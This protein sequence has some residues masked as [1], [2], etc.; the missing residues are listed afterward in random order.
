MPLISVL[1]PVRQFDE[2][3][4]PAIDSVL[5]QTHENLELLLITYP[6]DHDWVARLPH[7]HRLKILPRH[8]DGIVSALN[9][10]IDAATGH[11]IAR[12]DADDL[13]TPERLSRQLAHLCEHDRLSM[14]GAQVEIFSDDTTVQTGNRDY[15]NWLNAALTPEQIRDNIYV[16]SPLPHPTLFAATELFRQFRYR[17]SA[18]AEDYDLLLRLHLAGLLMGKPD[19]ILLRWREH[20]QRL[21]RQSSR[22]SIAQFLNAKAWALSQQYPNRSIWLCG[23]GRNAVH[24]HDALQ[25]HG[26]TVT[27][28][29]EHDDARARTSR[30]HLP[31]ITYTELL[32]EPRAELI[33]N[34]VSARGVR[35]DLRALFRNSGLREQDDFVMAR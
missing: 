20:T 13:A 4:L 30:R 12:M 19:A 10:G 23:V 22:Y 28:F 8:T 25:N 3:L 32:S 18:W 29:V 11:Y 9:T 31:V 21:T 34:T 5:T 2:F 14:V 6:G 15:Q 7:D 33:V 17:D 26:V 24:L 16:E 1:L 35:E 27:G